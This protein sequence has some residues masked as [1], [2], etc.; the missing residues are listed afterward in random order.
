MTQAGAPTPESAKAQAKAPKALS[1]AKLRK[2]ADDAGISIGGHHGSPSPTFEQLSAFAAGVRDLCAE[3]C[4]SIAELYQ[5]A[6]GP[7]ASAMKA[8]ALEC[9][10]AL[11]D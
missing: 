10:N 9:P 1:V 6:D 3:Q 11:K 5:Q 4:F 8:G 7:R 2:L